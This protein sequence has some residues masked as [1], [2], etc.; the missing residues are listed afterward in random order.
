LPCGRML[1]FLLF[2]LS[3]NLASSFN[4]HALI[5]SNKPLNP[6][7]NAHRDYF[8]TMIN[9]VPRHCYWSGTS[10]ICNGVCEG[11]HDETDRKDTIDPYN[12]H[13]GA[14]CFGQSTKALC[15]SKIK[16]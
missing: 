13:F 8:D 5:H 15:C 10:P 7:N 1:V 14:P 2:L 16:H 6:Y 4:P 12:P 11:D 3:A 9:G